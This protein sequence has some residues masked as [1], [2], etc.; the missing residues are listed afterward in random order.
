MLDPR[1]LDPHE[2]LVSYR[3]LADEEV[4]QIVRLL[5]A[6]REWREVEQRDS[7]ESRGRMHLN[8]TDMRA[9]RFLIAAKNQGQ[10]VTAGALSAHLGISTASTTKLLDRLAASGHIARAPHPTDRRAI[11]V[12]IT[13]HTHEEVRESVGRRHARRFE[14]AA[15]LSPDERDVVIRFLRDLAAPGRDSPDSR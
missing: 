1:I 12:T 2:E 7:V 3:D 15:R 13:P 9:L 6:M 4:S 5:T 14:V 11:T 8:E 10:A